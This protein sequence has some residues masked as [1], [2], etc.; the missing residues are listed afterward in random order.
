MIGNSDLL[1]HQDVLEVDLPVVIQANHTHVV[2][3]SF[4]WAF[5]HSSLLHHFDFFAFCYSF[6]DISPFLTV[7]S[8]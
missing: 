2:W 8:P 3:I 5:Y 7:F 6:T 1:W 4:V